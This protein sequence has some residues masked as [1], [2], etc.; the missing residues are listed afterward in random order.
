VSSSERLV[1]A[2]ARSSLYFANSGLK[3]RLNLLNTGRSWWTL[4]V[5]VLLASL[6]KI[7]PVTLASKLFTRQSW[8]YCASMGVLMN[9]RGIVQLVVLNIGVQLK[10]IS[11]V[12]FAMFV[13]MATILTLLTSPILSFLYGKVT[14]AD[15]SNAIDEKQQHDNEH[16]NKAFQRDSSTGDPKDDASVIPDRSMTK[17]FS[18][19]SNDQSSCSRNHATGDVDRPSID[20]QQHGQRRHRR[21]TLF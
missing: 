14:Q 2:N 21:M 17:T 3:T 18:F 10:V 20:N 7:I 8:Y 11:P 5:L 16:S 9:T 12:I 13:L 1:D 19:S 15:P 4:A 6:A